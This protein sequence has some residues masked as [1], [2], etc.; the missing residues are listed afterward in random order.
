MVVYH[1]ILPCSCFSTLF[2]STRI[3]EICCSRREKGKAVTRE[4][5]KRLL[6]YDNLCIKINKEKYIYNLFL[7]YLV[8]G[9]EKWYVALRSEFALNLIPIPVLVF[10]QYSGKIIVHRAKTCFANISLISCECQIYRYKQLIELDC[11]RIFPAVLST[12]CLIW[13]DS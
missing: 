8:R 6:R 3:E 12:D 2:S 13:A 5:N 4:R 10:E 11:Y 7:P 9:F 1:A